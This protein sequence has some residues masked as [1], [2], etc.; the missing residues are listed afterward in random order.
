MALKSK[1]W[2]YKQCII[3]VDRGSS[4]QDLCWDIMRKGIGQIEG[5][6]GHVTQA[7]GATQKFL[8]EHPHHV[9]TI[10]ASSRTDPFDLLNDPA[11]LQD[12][13]AWFGNQTGQYGRKAFGY[14]YDTLYRVLTDN[15]GGEVDHN[16]GGGADDEFRRVLRLMAEFQGRP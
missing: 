3:E 15:L 14:N 5:T 6:R 12:W 9:P 13:V 2:F 7:I 8:A 10:S 1:E 16:A 11:I 4:L